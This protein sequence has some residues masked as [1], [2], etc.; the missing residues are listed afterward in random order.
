VGEKLTGGT[1]DRGRRGW[2]EGKETQW[3]TS[4][5]SEERGNLPNK[6]VCK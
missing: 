5:G 3:I 2:V 6:F 4:V 1:G